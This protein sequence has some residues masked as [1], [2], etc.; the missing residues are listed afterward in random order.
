MIRHAA[1]WLAMCLPVLGHELALD[2][3]MQQ[4]ELML[5]ASY[6]PGEPAA[7]IAVIAAA[8]GATPISGE[9]DGDGA[10]AFTPPT[11]GEWTLRVDDGYGHLATR[12]V[13]VNWAD[14]AP[15]RNE[16]ASLW[17][18]AGAGLAVISGLTAF[19]VWG[20]RRPSVQ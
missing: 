9:T 10:F 13:V 1:L 3:E 17:T 5:R 18:R 12:T 14:P 2:V 7:Q 19:V 4:P 20:R 15:E 8:E 6:G 11:E 16:Q